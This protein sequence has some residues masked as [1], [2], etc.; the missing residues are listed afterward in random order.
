VR[1]HSE[2]GAGLTLA[3]H[4][5]D[6]YLIKIQSIRFLGHR[7]AC[8]SPY[9]SSATPCPSGSA[10]ASGDPGVREG[11]MSFE[12]DRPRAADD[13]EVIRARVAEL[14]GERGRAGAMERRLRSVPQT[15][16]GQRTDPVIV[17]VR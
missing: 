10:A 13:F 11:Q 12:T 4:F 15:L 3:G 16:Q 8:E 6:R 7:S 2:R 1:L 5:V 9:P 14:R 17:P